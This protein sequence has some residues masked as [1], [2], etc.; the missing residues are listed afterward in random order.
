MNSK[1]DRIL[2]KAISFQR[3]GRSHKAGEL[4]QQ[5]LAIDPNQPD[6]L[7]HLGVMAHEAGQLEEAVQLLVKSL[8]LNSNH[9]EAFDAL[10]SVLKDQRRF[11]EAVEFYQNALAIS[12]KAAYLH[13]NLGLVFNEMQLLNEAIACYQRALELDPKLG[14]AYSNLGAVYQRQGEHQKALDC[15]ERALAFNPR[16]MVV[17]GN[18]GAILND[19]GRFSEAVRYHEA[20]LKIEPK[21]D[22][23][24]NNLGV[25]F[26]QL[27]R[28]PEAIHCYQRA[29]ELNPKSYSALNNLGNVFREQRAFEKAVVCLKKAVELQPDCSQTRNSLGAALM[30]Q[31]KLDEA[32][33]CFQK[34]LELGAADPAFLVKVYRN[35]G[36]THY[37]AGQ[38]GEAVRYY[39]R[40]LG[41]DPDFSDAFS[42]MLFILN[43]LHQETP[44]ALFAEH[45]RFGK[46]F[47]E[48]LI[49]RI[50]AHS[51]TPE[52]HRRLRI[53]FVSG[54]LRAHAVANFIE[55][56]FDHYTKSEF[57]FFCYENFPVN[58]VV[59]ER[60]IQKVD[61]WRNVDR[62]SDEELADQIR[63]DAIDILVDLSG[64]TGLNRLLVFA[65]KPAPVQ[66]TMLG[67]VQTTGLTTI[68]YRI[69]DEDLNP[70]GIG[71]DYS[72]E[73][74]IRF[75]GCASSFTPPE[76]CPPV[77]EPPALKNGFITFGSFNKPSKITSEMF[78]AWSKILTA[79]PGARLLV[80]GISSD[81]VVKAMASHGIGPERLELHERKSTAEYLE[82]HH[83]VDLAL[84][85]YPYNGGTTSLIAS[86]MGV[87]FVTLQGATAISRSGAGALKIVGLNELIA[88]NFDDYVQKAIAAVQDLQQLA[89]W[90]RQ[91]RSRMLLNIGNGKGY[92]KQLESAFREMWQTWCDQALIQKQN[93][94]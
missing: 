56:V 43:H 4:F 77:N 73:K 13:S 93:E 15:Y 50:K 37:A 40:L 88:V 92:S 63:K 85:T 31:G 7:Y 14:V 9:A 49:A 60:L 51:N 41:L 24:Q 44:D 82:L 59:S 45:L 68:D 65:R 83:R 72:T 53:G 30:E 32:L 62:L 80:A 94:F 8:Q 66:V 35:M 61:S 1:I 48:R 78:E 75:S 34:A 47:G 79:T 12:P 36:V 74:L 91:L 3:A 27:H 17:L 57:E 76:H 52:K 16:L 55:P 23:V 42:E 18:M 29:L 58:D 5:V 33:A 69:T 28:M 20:A 19:L 25:A 70:A 38:S 89:E 64:H 10:A 90:R 26:Y 71:D 11:P 46:Q 39:R 86:W 84:D 87:P 81:F 2:E 6:A 21:L 22:L 54:D 67:Y